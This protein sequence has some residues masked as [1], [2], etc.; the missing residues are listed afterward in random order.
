[1]A[2]SDRTPRCKKGDSLILIDCLQELVL[3]QTSFRRNMFE[4]CMIKMEE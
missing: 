3:E 4:K 2:S 1:M